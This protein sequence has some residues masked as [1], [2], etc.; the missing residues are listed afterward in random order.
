M[1]LSAS[2]EKRRPRSSND[3][4]SGPAGVNDAGRH[5]RC[6]YEKITREVDGITVAPLSL[7]TFLCGGA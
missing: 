6:Y 3:K 5:R 7:T 4:A 2:R 1:S